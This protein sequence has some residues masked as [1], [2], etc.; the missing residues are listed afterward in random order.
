MNMRE[1]A[2]LGCTI[3]W[4]QQTLISAYED[5]SPLRPVKTGR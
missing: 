3:D 2:G 1:E 4:V 5:N